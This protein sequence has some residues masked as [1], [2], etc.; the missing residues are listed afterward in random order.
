MIIKTEKEQTQGERGD[1]KGERTREGIRA[2]T[3]ERDIKIFKLRY[4]VCR[5]PRYSKEMDGAYGDKKMG[6]GQTL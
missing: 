5:S 2:R 6:E 1:G 4:L 3:R